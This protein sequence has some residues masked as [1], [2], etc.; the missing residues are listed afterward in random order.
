MSD[1]CPIS[2]NLT[3]KQAAFFAAADREGFSLGVLASHMGISVETL[4]SYIDKPSRKAS[5]MPLVTFIKLSRVPGLP[6]HVLGLLVE[7][8]AFD[9]APRDPL[10]TNWLALGER[11]SSFCAKVLRF[12]SSNNH[13]DHREEVEL[14]EDV[15][16][17]ISESQGALAAR[18]K[19]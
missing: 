10:R 5:L 9:L 14:C 1:D 17:I 2:R 3:V 4:R 16:G 8:A 19:G 15:L 6:T 18:A 11:M 13:I 7:D 12:Q